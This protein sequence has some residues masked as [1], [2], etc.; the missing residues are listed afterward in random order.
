VN[1]VH[2]LKILEA[3]LASL[4]RNIT[5]DKICRMY[6]EAIVF[7]RRSGFLQD[8][9]LANYLCFQ[10]CVE[11]QELLVAGSYLSDAYSLWK[12]WNAYAVAD[13]L[14]RRHADFVD[15]FSSMDSTNGSHRSREIFN[16]SL[17]EQHRVLSL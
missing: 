13:S 16:S 9:A 6:D 14:C 17:A 1:I 10:V 4:S 11:R 12:M 2:K 3:E 8:A 15:A 5:T 7:T